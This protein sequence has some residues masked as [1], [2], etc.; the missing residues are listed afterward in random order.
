VWSC[1]PASRPPKKK[2]P[3]QKQFCASNI[4]LD[5]HAHNSSQYLRSRQTTDVIFSNM[6]SKDPE[7]RKRKRKHAKIAKSINNL[8]EISISCNKAEQDAPQNTPAPK[9][10]KKEKKSGST[11]LPKPAQ[12]II[13]LEEDESSEDFDVEL[14]EDGD[15]AEEADD[16][17]ENNDNEHMNAARKQ[18]M[19]MDVDS[20]P[21]A[22]PTTDDENPLPTL[23][24]DAKD[25]K[26]LNLSDRTMKAITEMGFETMTEIQQRSIPPLLAGKDVLGA[27]KTGSGKT[28][29]FLIPAVEMLSSLRFKPRN[30]IAV[31][32]IF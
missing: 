24:E 31:D 4:L 29:A 3:E 8:D 1:L 15:N 5:D 20:E 6:D 25:F 22:L 19:E 10:P 26:H 7:T 23:D 21:A 14:D 32:C 28:L 27:A 30:G 17:D 18:Q 13:P 2:I 9:K 11:L 16:N 12:P